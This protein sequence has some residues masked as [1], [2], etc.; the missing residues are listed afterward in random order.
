[1]LFR[2]LMEQISSLEDQMRVVSMRQTYLTEEHKSIRS[3]LE[4]G[5]KSANDQ[6]NL[7][8]NDLVNQVGLIDNRLRSEETRYNII[9]ER[10]FFYLFN[11]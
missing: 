7:L 1:M 3:K 4:I 8:L 9:F 6:T 10:V 5:F 11:S 2:S